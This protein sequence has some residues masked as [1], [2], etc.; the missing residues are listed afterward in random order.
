MNVK[1]VSDKELLI[2]LKRRIDEDLIRVNDFEERQIVFRYKN[3][4]NYMMPGAVIN[5]VRPGLTQFK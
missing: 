3:E 2:E 5:R 1:E 4:N